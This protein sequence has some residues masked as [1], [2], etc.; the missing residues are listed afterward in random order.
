MATTGFGGGGGT[1]TALRAVALM[2]AIDRV[3]GCEFRLNDIVQLLQVQPTRRA[4]AS[5]LPAQVA[6]RGREPPHSFFLC[7]FTLGAEMRPDFVG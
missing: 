1:T 5:A 3:S 6:R 4:V 2:S 7:G